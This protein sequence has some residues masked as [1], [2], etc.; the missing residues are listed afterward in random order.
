MTVITLTLKDID[1]A[2]KTLFDAFAQDPMLLW[3][4]E[5]EKGYQEKALW[6]FKSWT[7]WA[8]LYGLAIATPDFEAV[9]LRKKP[10]HHQFTFWNL[11]RS[12]MLLSKKNCGDQVFNNMMAL[13][14]ILEKEQQKNMGDSPYWYCWLIGTQTSQQGLGHAKKLM[15]YTFDVASAQQ[16]PCY[17]ETAS[18]KSFHVHEQQGYKLCSK[19]Q[20][21]NSQVYLY[22]MVKRV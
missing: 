18:E 21:P 22:S 20:I 7:K 17:L 3:M 6:A 1:P 9:A 5:D 15:Q 12:G 16:L 4:F 2:A 13:D 14:K 8:I 10:G 19:V 11:L